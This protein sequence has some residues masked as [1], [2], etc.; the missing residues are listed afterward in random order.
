MKVI[1]LNYNYDLKK[2]SEIGR[3]WAKDVYVNKDYISNYSAASYA[4][5]IDKNP[6]LKLNLYTDDIDD[7]KVRMSKYNINQDNII[8]HDYTNNLKKYQKNLRYSFDVL[9]DFI[10]FARSRDE[11]TVKIDNDLIFTGPLPQ[12]NDINNDVLVWE[13]ERLVLNGNPKMGEVKVSSE[14]I[15]DI[16]YPIYNLGLFGLPPTYPEE[17][18]MEIYEKMVSVDIIDVSDLNVHTW[19]C[20][21]QTANNWIFYKQNYNVIQ[22]SGIVKHHYSNKQQCINDAKYLLK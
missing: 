7:M 1:A 20:A 10:H 11:F 9:N 18:F 12:I 3:V 6:H 14:V 16:N 13:Y 15:G 22:T 21:E 5:F 4:T 8:Y 19:H 17:Y 2:L